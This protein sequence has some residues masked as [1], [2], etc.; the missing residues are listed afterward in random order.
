LFV[1]YWSFLWRPQRRKLHAMYEK[2][3]MDAHALRWYG[4]RFCLWDLS[5]INNVT[6]LVC[7][8]WISTFLCFVTI[9]CDFFVRYL[10]PQIS[11]TC[12]PNLGRW[13]FYT[14]FP[15]QNLW[16]LSSNCIFI[17]QIKLRFYFDKFYNI[18]LS[19]IAV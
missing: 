10:H 8:F 19:L 16:C 11:K 13:R 14:R 4:W 2:F 17:K 1:L 7:I 12:A 6:F 18:F 3:Q 9:L 5:G 15:V